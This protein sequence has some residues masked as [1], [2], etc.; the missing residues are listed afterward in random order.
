MCWLVSKVWQ[1][2]Q[3]EHTLNRGVWAAMPAMCQGWEIYVA[4][5]DRF[6]F[7]IISLIFHTQ[8][9][10][11]EWVLMFQFFQMLRHKCYGLADKVCGRCQCDKKTC[12]NVVVEVSLFS[13]IFF[14]SQF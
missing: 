11:T 6:F 1:W 7:N 4:V 3:V 12:H 9:K 5:S 10:L 8:G 13:L 14:C 2:D